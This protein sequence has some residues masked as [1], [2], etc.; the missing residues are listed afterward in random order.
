ML[1]TYRLIRPKFWIIRNNFSRAARPDRYKSLFFFSLSVLFIAG[2]LYGS[3]AFFQKLAAE[4][5]FGMILV[6]KLVE[7]LFMTFLAVM[8]FSSIVTSLSAFFLDADLPLIVTA[9]ITFGRLY[10]ARFLQTLAMTGWMVVMFGLPV[11]IACGVVFD[12][13]WFFYPWT[14][15]VLCSF[16]I[17]PVAVGSLLTI[18]LV[19]AFPARKLQDIFV[20]LAVLL[21][22]VLYFLFRFV[23]PEQ[24]FNPDIFHGF[25]EYFATLKTP[26][27]PLLPSTWGSLALLAPLD[28]KL[29]ENGVFFV[30]QMLAWGM[31]AVLI[32]STLAKR[33]LRGGKT[34]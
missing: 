4:E 34:L 29:F 17:L 32:G 7:F 27:S 15:L 28:G 18:V 8:V 14:L 12:A 21:I 33:A 5:P 20:I 22:V 9:P 10:V 3:M 13:P 25:A 2:L 1:D 30:G 26:D 16:V 24:L 19:R 6:H 31:F 11:F 23:R